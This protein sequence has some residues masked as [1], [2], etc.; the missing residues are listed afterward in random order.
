ML[1]ILLQ[2][3]APCLSGAAG[4]VNTCMDGGAK[5]LAPNSTGLFQLLHRDCWISEAK[6]SDLNTFWV[7]AA[8]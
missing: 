5:R 8:K 4:Q 2:F 6:N 3:A 1:T 7:A